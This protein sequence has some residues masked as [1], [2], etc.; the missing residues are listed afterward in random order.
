MNA[1][2]YERTKPE[3]KQQTW[4]LGKMLHVGLTD[5]H[6]HEGLLNGVV[7]GQVV[8]FWH[9]KSSSASSSLRAEP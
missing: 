2:R 1:G 7:V 8:M 3:W 4:R 5:S 9:Q 6:V